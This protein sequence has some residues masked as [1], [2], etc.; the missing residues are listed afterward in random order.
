MP[1]FPER[2]FHNLALLVL[3]VAASA[4]AQQPLTWDQVR[5]RFEQHNPTLMASKLSIDESKAQEITA[6]LRPNPDFTFS[7]RRHPSR[8]QSW[9]LAAPCRNFRNSRHQPT[10]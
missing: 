2:K 4:S 7:V 10:H 6:A 9:R 5:D 8:P 3:L 1:V